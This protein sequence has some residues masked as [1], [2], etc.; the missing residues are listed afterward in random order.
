MRSF[1]VSDIRRQFSFHTYCYSRVMTSIVA[2]IACFIMLLIV[3]YD[4]FKTAVVFA[5]V[6]FKITE[7]LS[8]VFQGEMQ[9]FGRMDFIGKSFFIKG[10][11]ELIVFLSL[12]SFTKNIL[13]ATS[14]LA[15]VSIILIISYD[16]RKALFLHKGDDHKSEN[17]IPFRLQLS[18]KYIND[19]VKLLLLCLPIALYS[20]LFNCVSQIPKLALEWLY[21]A[22]MMGIY[23]SIAMPVTIIQVSANYIITPLTTPLATYLAE[24]NT[25]GFNRLVFK[26]LKIVGLLSAVAIILFLLFGNCAYVL[27][28]GSSIREYTYLGLPLIVCGI[29]TALSWFISTLFV[30]LRRHRALFCF[31]LIAF[32]CSSGLSYPLLNIFGMNGATFAQ[33]IAMILFIIIGSTYMVFS[34]GN[35]KP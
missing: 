6:I 10:A 21:G 13:I 31:S 1:Q 32:L 11:L 33:I 9:L 3:Q 5:Y 22:D 18:H 7:A 26:T 30:V 20:L 2:I 14:S 35:R 17:T 24:G 29:T 8:D 19:L 4:S 34:V 28:F 15:L 16:Y 23:S 12:I 25:S 27:F